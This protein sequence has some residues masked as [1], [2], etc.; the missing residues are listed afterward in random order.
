MPFLSD[1]AEHVHAGSVTFFELI[2]RR[3]AAAEERMRC[4]VRNLKRSM[5]THLV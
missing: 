2:V 3:Q 5:L 4:E 1:E